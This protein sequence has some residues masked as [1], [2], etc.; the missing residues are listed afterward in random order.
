MRKKWKWLLIAVP[1]I[2]VTAGGLYYSA[3]VKNP[4]SFMSEDRIINEID[5]QFQN[6]KTQEILDI[7]FLTDR[8]V[9]VPFRSDRN[10]YGVA[11][12]EWKLNDWE[13]ILISSSGEPSIV[14]TNAGDPASQY[15]LWNLHPD[16]EVKR[17]AFYLTRRRNFQVLQ[18]EQMYTPRVQMKEE[19]EFEKSYGSMKIPSDWGTYMTSYQEALTREGGAPVDMFS[20][21]P[22]MHFTYGWIPYNSQNEIAELNQTMGQSG[23]SSGYSETI[24]QLDPSELESGSE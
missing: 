1:L 9:F 19:I 13:L 20:N 10:Q 4:D 7:D 2:L 17:A 23:F 22:Q 16:D 12:W 14:T 3:V 15:V 18:G 21:N 5:S 6:G 24:L 8:H 11:Y